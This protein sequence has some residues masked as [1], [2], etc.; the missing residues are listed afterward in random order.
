MKIV[1]K[2][3]ITALSLLV[4]ANIV[5]GIAIS[6]F[7]TALI[8]AVILGIINLTIRPLVLLFTIPIN[9]ISLGLFTFVINGLLFWFAS[10]FI[11]GFFVDGFLS[12]F[13]GAL[14]VSVFSWLSN[15]F[16]SKTE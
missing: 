1:A 10:T 3:L 6:N 11:K 15:H 7:Y 12:A 16:I 4:V 14:I 13:I 5:P 8:V 2:I 9:I